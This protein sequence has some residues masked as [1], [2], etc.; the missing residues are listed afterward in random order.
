MRDKLNKVIK[1]REGFRPFAPSVTM[2]TASKWFD[3]RQSV[4]YM[5][6]VTQNTSKKF[7]AATHIDGSCRVQTV[8]KYQNPLYFKLIKEIGKKSG[9]EVVLNTSYNLKDQTIT[10]TPQQAIERFLDSDIDNLVIDKFIIS[11]K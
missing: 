1:K 6:I 5:N 8:D 9:A 11:K 10:R 7:K 3:V 2:E 4:P